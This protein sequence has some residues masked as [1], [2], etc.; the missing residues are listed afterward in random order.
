MVVSITIEPQLHEIRAFSL[1]TPTCVHI[2]SVIT[3]DQ[4][5]D[6]NTNIQELV[7]L[8]E[9]QQP[10]ELMSCCLSVLKRRFCSFN[11]RIIKFSIARECF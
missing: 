10:G 11:E 1:R 8:V 4:N 2:Y 6:R 7:P 3:D 9:L 5:D